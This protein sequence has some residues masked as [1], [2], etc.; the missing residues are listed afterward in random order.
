MS[1]GDQ[2]NLFQCRIDHETLQT[3]G[4]EWGKCLQG[5]CWHKVEFS[6]YQSTVDF[7]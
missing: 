1:E 7:K 2:I 6:V 5:Y 3:G 4:S